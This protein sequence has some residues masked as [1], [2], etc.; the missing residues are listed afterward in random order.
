[1][2]PRSPR[3]YA[4]PTRSPSCHR[5][6]APRR[7]ATRGTRTN[8][9]RNDAHRPGVGCEQ[10][11]APARRAD[12]PA[13]RSRSSRGPTSRRPSARPRRRTRRSPVDGVA[14][15]TRWLLGASLREASRVHAHPDGPARLVPGRGFGRWL[16]R[17][18][19]RRRQRRGRL[20]AGR[21][22][23]GHRVQAVHPARPDGAAPRVGTRVLSPQHDRALDQRS[24]RCARLDSGA[25]DRV[26][27]DGRGRDSR[28]S[29]QATS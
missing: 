29:S 8:D 19:L 16:P 14:P 4:T 22:R 28:C 11:P 23:G 27:P 21:T 13:V 10:R 1:M 9:R 20:R 25:A 24:D 7:R 6:S 15:A 18:P 3:C 26:R 5:P 17:R 12:G 2:E